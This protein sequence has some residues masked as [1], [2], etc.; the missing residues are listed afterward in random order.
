MSKMA[1][2][3]A[4]SENAL[5]AVLLEKLEQNNL[6]INRKLWL[7]TRYLCAMAKLGGALSCLLLL[8]GL[9]RNY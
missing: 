2:K 9:Q 4:A 5:K 1:A 8:R 3:Q 6:K 7:T